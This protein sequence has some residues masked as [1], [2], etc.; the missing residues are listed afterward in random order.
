[1]DHD[2]R[3]KEPVPQHNTALADTPRVMKEALDALAENA[4]D[5]TLV[6]DTRRTEPAPPRVDLDV[7]DRGRDRHVFDAPQLNEPAPGRIGIRDRLVDRVIRLP[8]C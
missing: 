6:V 1:M 7:V 2:R 5:L 8:A 3:F 4:L